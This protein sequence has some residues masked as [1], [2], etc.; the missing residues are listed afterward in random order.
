MCESSQ[1]LAGLEKLK[2]IGAPVPKYQ[3]IHNI[4]DI[5]SL[6]IWHVKHGWTVRSCRR[7]GVREIGLLY[8]NYI[9]TEEI[10]SLLTRLLEQ[11]SPSLFFIIY[12]SWK[13]RLSFNILATENEIIVEGVHGSQKDIAI[14]SSSPEFS[15][16]FTT[17]LSSFLQTNLANA[18]TD[19]RQPLGKSFFFLRKLN[20]QN[21][22]AEVAVTEDDELLFYELMNTSNS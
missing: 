22:Y 19:L 17:G 8:Y 14:G 20:L 1:R 4:A 13:F 12:P 9:P 6:N 18:P 10:S 7:D 5:N 15:I 16:L 21:V 3:V 11:H 2:V